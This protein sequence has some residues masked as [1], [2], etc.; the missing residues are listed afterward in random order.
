MCRLRPANQ[1]C[2]GCPLTFGVKC[3]LILHF[4]EAA[5]FVAI[6]LA[7][8]LA[9]TEVIQLPGNPNLQVVRM[10][11]QLVAIVFIAV[12]WNGVINRS[13]MNVRLYYL[14]YVVTVILLLV[15]AV[16]DFTDDKCDNVPDILAKGGKK[17]GCGIQRVGLFAGQM[18][19]W[20]LRVYFLHMVWSFLQD[21]ATKG[22]GFG[23]D[24]LQYQHK[25]S[26]F[27]KEIE[28]VLFEKQPLRESDFDEA[29]AKQYHSLG[30]HAL[31]HRNEYS[32]HELCQDYYNKPGNTSAAA[33]M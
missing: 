12:G 33:R 20:C 21:L 6:A 10:A 13:E 4:I 19:V 16:L 5:F 25:S 32:P 11:Y 2:C 23:L 14:F 24:G 15:F 18:A 8:Q 29:A 9:D 1:C 7:K 27:V 30:I 31:S 17:F 26:W 22:D 3:I 28:N